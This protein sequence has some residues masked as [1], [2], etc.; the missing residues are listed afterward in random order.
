MGCLAH[1][2]NAAVDK[3]DEEETQQRW[4]FLRNISLIIKSQALNNFPDLSFSF[5]SWNF[6]VNLVGNAVHLEKSQSPWR[7]LFQ[8]YGEPSVKKL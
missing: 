1:H 6:L 8:K 4:L 7:L 5:T 3:I 2:I